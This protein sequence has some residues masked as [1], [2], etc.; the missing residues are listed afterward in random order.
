MVSFACQTL[1]MGLWPQDSDRL[2][3]TQQYYTPLSQL[4]KRLNR[5]FNLMY[6]VLKDD[7]FKEGMN[8]AKIKKISLAKPLQCLEASKLLIKSG[9]LEEWMKPYL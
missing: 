1:A 8:F 4:D 7:W 2:E 3:K 5:Y 6:H 9:S